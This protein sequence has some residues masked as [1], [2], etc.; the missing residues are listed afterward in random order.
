MNISKG[1]TGAAIAFAFG[2]QAAADE[3]FGFGVTGD[4]AD[5]CDIPDAYLVYERETDGL[6]AHGRVHNKGNRVC[7]AAVSA[8]IL[9]ER[10]FGSV[11]VSLGYDRRGVS[12]QGDGERFDAEVKESVFTTTPV[13]FYGSM[14]TAIAAISYDFD[15]FGVN[16]EAGFDLV[17][18]QPRLQGTYDFNGLELQ[19]DATAQSL[20]RPFVT[21]AASY[22]VEIN[23]VWGVEF[24]AG[25]DYGINNVEDG[26]AWKSD[27]LDDYVWQ[28]A[29]PPETAYRYSIGVTRRM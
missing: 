20:G 1:L 2:V 5:G 7:K 4:T 25:Y 22:V 3:R 11:S 27:P 18:Q 26:I 28:P 17:G 24:S 9:I 13:I 29:S 23:D 6:N 21:F 14:D 8:D 12:F 19:A 15:A 16:W 10:D